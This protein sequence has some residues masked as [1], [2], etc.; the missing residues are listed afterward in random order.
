MTISHYDRRRNAPAT[1]HQQPAELFVWVNPKIRHES[2]RPACKPSLSAENERI[3]SRREERRAAKRNLIEKEWSR[4]SGPRRTRGAGVVALVPRRRP[5]RGWDLPHQYLQR[6]IGV[7]DFARGDRPSSQTLSARKLL[8]YG[9][10]N[11][12]PAQPRRLL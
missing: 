3:L 5:P 9:A 8:R 1:N 6:S 11:H 7:S 12:A 4:G 2:E 10:A